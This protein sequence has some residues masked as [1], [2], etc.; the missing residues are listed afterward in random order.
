VET[1]TFDM[2]LNVQ[3]SETILQKGLPLETPSW[4]S[5]NG[6]LSTNFFGLHFSPVKY[7]FAAAFAVYPRA[8][9]LLFVQALFVALGSVP[10]YKLSVHFLQDKRSSLLVTL[11]YLV[12]PPL[13][14]SNLYDVHEE[15]LLPFAV[16]SAYYFFVTKRYSRAMSFFIFTG[17]VQESA[18]A[19]IF[20]AALQLLSLNWKDYLL[21]LRTRRWTR[22]TAIVVSLLVA[23]PIAFLLENRLFLAINPSAG[24]IPFAQTAYA[25]NPLNALS[26][27]PQKAS[28]WFALFGLVGFLPFLYKRSLILAVPWLIVSIF[29]GNPSFSLLFFQY[30]FFAIPALFIGVIQGLVALHKWNFPDGLSFKRRLGLLRRLTHAPL[31]RVFLLLLIAVSLLFTPFYPI[32]AGYLPAHPH[33]VQYYLP[34]SNYSQLEQLYGLIPDGASVLSSDNIFAHVAK[35]INVYPILYGYNS[36]TGKQYL[37]THLPNGFVPDY[38]IIQP[39]DNDTTVALVGSFP[40][41]YSVTGQATVQYTAIAG[42][43]SRGEQGLTVIL[44][45]HD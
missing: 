30:S 26:Y 28:Y 22:E 21:L 17:L 6:A 44:Y 13:I 3:L 41:S 4:T 39:S 38:I 33:L 35:S 15:S 19:L 20:F 9:T 8:S 43:N 7:I 1:P 24:F 12:F 27:V 14:M 16:L 5:S 18:N 32:L 25:I 23:S 31:D 36:T 40:H 37:S 29:G 34:P 42:L 2:G 11:L 10:A 45:Q